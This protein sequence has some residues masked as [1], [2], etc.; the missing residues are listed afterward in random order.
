AEEVAQRAEVHLVLQAGAPGLQQQR[1]VGEAAHGVE[2]PLAT[3]PVEPQRHAVALIA[4]RQQQRAAGV[5]AEAGAEEAGGLEATAQ[6]RQQPLA[7]DEREQLLARRL[8][9]HLVRQL[10]GERV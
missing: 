5:L 10:D 3:L 7:V 4:A 9:L 6:Q 8:R 1:E 2:Q